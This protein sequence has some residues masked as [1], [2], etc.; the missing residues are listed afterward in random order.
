MFPLR[1]DIPT[2]RTP[3][4]TIALIVANVI[5]FLLSLRDGGSLW[6]GPTNA[7]AVECGNVPQSRK[8]SETT[9]GC[10]RV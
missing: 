4:L 3:V 7:F 10:N 6:S 9:S 1:D 2:D 5:V 8:R